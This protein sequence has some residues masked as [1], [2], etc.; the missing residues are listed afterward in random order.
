MRAS[1]LLTTASAALIASAGLALAQPHERGDGAGGPG[2]G[3]HAPGGGLAAPAQ[4][5]ERMLREAPR[6]EEIKVPVIIA[7]A[8][9]PLRG[10]S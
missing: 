6:A 4:V 2:A 8:V 3:M 7:R 1:L 9:E 10:V 5:A